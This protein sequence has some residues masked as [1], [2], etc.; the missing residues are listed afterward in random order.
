[1]RLVLR[2]GFNSIVVV[3]AM[4]S[5]LVVNY[6]LGSPVAMNEANISL[7]SVGSISMVFIVI[8]RDIQYQ[9]RAKFITTLSKS[10]A[11]QIVSHN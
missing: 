1:M 9:R 5:L 4:S 11:K 10:A 6:L 3:I 2:Y 7:I 8:L